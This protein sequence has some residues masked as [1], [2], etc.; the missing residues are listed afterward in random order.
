MNI[1]PIN[2]KSINFG[3]KIKYNSFFEKGFELAKQSTRAPRMKDLDYSQKFV[4][5]V[6][7]ILNDGSKKTLE[8]N[9]EKHNPGILSQEGYESISLINKYAENLKP[10]NNQNKELKEL[11]E[12]V[13]SASKTLEE[14]KSQYAQSLRK[15]LEYLQNMI[16][17]TK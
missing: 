3:A 10:G 7:S 5:S 13:E 11:K 4:D 15:Y 2:S 16:K 1:N 6:S 8:F 12:M 14:L 9:P 17:N